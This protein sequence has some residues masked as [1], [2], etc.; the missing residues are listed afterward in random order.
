MET[1]ETQIALQ[2]HALRQGASAFGID[3]PP[4]KRKENEERQRG[5]RKKIQH[6][7]TNN[8]NVTMLVFEVWRFHGD[9]MRSF[10]EMRSKLRKTAAS[11]MDQTAP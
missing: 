2:G 5:K 9:F 6:R 3:S 11:E 1:Q 7:D 10:C 8:R 4:K